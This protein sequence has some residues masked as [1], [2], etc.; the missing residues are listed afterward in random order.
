MWSMK[1]TPLVIFVTF[2][3]LGIYDLATVIFGHGTYGTISAFMVALGFKAPFVVFVC[4][5]C[6]GHFF[7]YMTQV[8]IKK[9]QMKGPYLKR[10]LGTLCAILMLILPCGILLLLTR[11]NCLYDF[12]SWLSE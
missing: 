10:I 1:T 4:G 3:V 7:F 2:I 9:Q 8:T 5:C 11:L 12:M 6:A